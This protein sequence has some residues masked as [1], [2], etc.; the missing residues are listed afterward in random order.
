MER[1]SIKIET[2]EWVLSNAN[3]GDTKSVLKINNELNN[4][5]L[6]RDGKVVRR[7]IYGTI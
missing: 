3:I 6:E 7:T 2:L 5:R 4:L 1:I